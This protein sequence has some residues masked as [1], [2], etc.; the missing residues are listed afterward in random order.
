MVL[1]PDDSSGIRDARRRRGV[2]YPRATFAAGFAPR[3]CLQLL[4]GGIRKSKATQKS[5]PTQP[6]MPV[7][8]IPFDPGIFPITS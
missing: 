4:H 8:G 7:Y 1:S 3:V 2:G 5:Q 6:V